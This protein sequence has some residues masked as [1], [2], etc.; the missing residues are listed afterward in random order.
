[1]TPV[2]SPDRHAFQIKV[3][4]S[5]MKCREMSLLTCSVVTTVAL[6]ELSWP[7]PARI[8]S[9]SSISSKKNP[10]LLVT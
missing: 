1:L 2:C 10:L 4:L 7:S 6:A 5:K 9:H 3:D 8:S